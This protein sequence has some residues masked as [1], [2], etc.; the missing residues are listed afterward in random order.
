MSI[1]FI[2]LLIFNIYV[3]FEN[4]TIENGSISLDFSFIKF[5]LFKEK[6]I[7]KLYL[8]LW[9]LTPT[10][11]LLCKLA[12]WEASSAGRVCETLEFL[13]SD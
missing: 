5:E 10:N 6:M 7:Q 3:N 2:L 1:I 12:L 9:N 13:A 8:R 11:V 4:K